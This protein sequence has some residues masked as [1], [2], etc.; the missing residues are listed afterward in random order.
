MSLG[1]Q[2]GVNLERS[3]L[4]SGESIEVVTVNDLRYLLP[5]RSRAMSFALLPIAV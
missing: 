1:R 3:T 5:S 2:T 4:S